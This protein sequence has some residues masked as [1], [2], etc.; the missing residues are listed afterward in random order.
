M[1]EQVVDKRVA[2]LPGHL[3]RAGDR[4]WADGTWWTVQGQTLHTRWDGLHAEV[5][6]VTEDGTE[7]SRWWGP[8]DWARVQ[9]GQ[10]T[11]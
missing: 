5:S 8:K 10:V 9:V 2:Q 3:L 11:Q 1:T 6:A 7:V 4:Y